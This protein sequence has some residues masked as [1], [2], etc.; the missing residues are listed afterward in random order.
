MNEL[1]Q[2]MLDLLQEGKEKYGYL[3]VKAEF[4]AEGTRHDELLRLAEITRRAGL[5]IGLKIGGC[6]AVTDLLTSKQL[7]IDYIIAPM[8]E[9]AYAL[10]KYIEAKNKI[11]SDFERK[12]VKFLFNVETELTFRNIDSIIACAKKD[13]GADG[14]VFGRVDYTLSKGFSRSDILSDK[15][16][17]DCI[18]I[19]RLCKKN[20]LELVVGGAV[21]QES[22]PALK[23]IKD[24]HL[25]RFE[26]RKVIFSADILSSDTGVEQG[27]KTA[28]MLELLW[29]QNKRNYYSSLEK[30]DMQRIV[31]LEKRLG[32]QK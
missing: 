5:N 9:S 27:I 23:K 30:E 25:T 14:V 12:Q 7:G 2:K 6:E 13:K 15:I 31:M 1:E 28:V 21:T 8:V 17:D 24:V 19:A 32:V 11:Y 26:T 16:T 20:D 4:E 18:E 29:L 22:I 10:S 3:G